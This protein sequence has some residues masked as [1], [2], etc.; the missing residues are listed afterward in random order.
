M[1][2]EGDLELGE[3]RQRRFMKGV[4][5]ECRADA[6][7]KLRFCSLVFRFIFCFLPSSSAMFDNS[8]W[9]QERSQHCSSKWNKAL[10]FEKNS[11]R[12]HCYE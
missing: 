8:S 12:A 6:M 2:N 1:G 3:E 5:C 9:M 7:T 4:S 10:A 11:S